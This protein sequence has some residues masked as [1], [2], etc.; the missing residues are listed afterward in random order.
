MISDFLAYKYNN[1]LQMSR[2]C[3]HDKKYKILI[4]SDFDGKCGALSGGSDPDEG[5]SCEQEGK[6]KELSLDVPLLED[7]H[8]ADE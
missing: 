8:S 5:H 2:L 7:D 1:I 6:V 4:C 3:M